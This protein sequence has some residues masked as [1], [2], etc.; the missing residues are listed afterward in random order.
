ME[1]DSFPSNGFPDRLSTISTEKIE[2]KLL[3]VA[4]KWLN[5]TWLWVSSFLIV[6]CSP[7]LIIQWT[8]IF[9]GCIT[10]GQKRE[11]IP[12]Q[13]ASVLFY[14]IYPV[15]LLMI[16]KI[17]IYCCLSMIKQTYKDAG[18]KAYCETPDNK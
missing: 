9:N 1:T 12:I 11:Q 7:C 2:K 18:C 4:S 8:G 13:I 16:C 17:L 15:Y 5:S 6:K 3:V 14:I 10:G